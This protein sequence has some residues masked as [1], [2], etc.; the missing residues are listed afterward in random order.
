MVTSFT[1]FYY[2]LI[3]IIKQKKSSSNSFLLLLEEHILKHDGNS[4][5]N[6]YIEFIFYLYIRVYMVFS[7]LFPFF[8]HIV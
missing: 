8:D 4:D 1:L 7:R 2:I 3:I 5:K 6:L